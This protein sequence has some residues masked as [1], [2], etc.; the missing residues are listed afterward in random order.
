MKD[1]EQQFLIAEDTEIRGYGDICGDTNTG[2][3]RQGGTECT[4]AELEAA[5]T[6]GFSAEVVISN[7]IATTIRDDH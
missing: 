2:E 6:K 4:E 7:G 3:G 1:V 5:A